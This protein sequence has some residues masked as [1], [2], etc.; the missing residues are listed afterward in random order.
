MSHHRSPGSPDPRPWS[1]RRG[2]AVP[3]RAA[4]PRPR[5]ACAASRRTAARRAGPAPQRARSVPGTH[6]PGGL[7]PRPSGRK[8]AERNVRPR[9]P[10]GRRRPRRWGQVPDALG[11]WPADHA[12]GHRQA[13]ATQRSSVV[14][15]APSP[16]TT[17]V[18]WPDGTATLTWSR[19]RRS[20]K[21]TE[22]A[23]VPHGMAGRSPAASPITGP[24]PAPGTHGSARSPARSRPC[25]AGPGRGTEARASRSARPGASLRARS[26]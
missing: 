20:P 24:R 18:T 16:P 22:T 19:A 7:P 1:A 4:W 17:A 11:A 25:R 3:A 2:R 10:R 5:P 12:R 14:L 21:L 23:S 13:P 6:R 15:P 9:P 8:T 26:R